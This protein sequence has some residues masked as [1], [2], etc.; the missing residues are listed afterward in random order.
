M[1][2]FIYGTLLYPP[3]FALVSGAP[4]R[5]AAPAFL[6]GFAVET[7]PDGPWPALVKRKGDTARGMV[8]RGLSPGQMRRLDAYERPFGYERAAITLQDEDGDDLEA[9]AWLPSAGQSASGRDWSL[10]AWVR[11]DAAEAMLAAAE[12]DWGAEDFD[13]ADILRQWPM[14]RGR[15]AAQLRASAEE[16]PAQV[17]R[18]PGQGDWNHASRG[19]M[20]GAFFRL[21]TMTMA[22]RRFDGGW[23]RD[24][25]REV[26]VGCDVAL[27]LP[28]DPVRDRVLLVEQFRAGPARRGD[29][30][31]WVLEPVAGIVDA[32]ETPE[33]A[34]LREAR[35]EAGLALAPGDLRPM[36]AAYPSPGNATDHFNAWAALTDLPD[37]F[38]ASGGVAAEGE[39]LRLHV[40]PFTRAME[41]LDSG[42]VT[43]V[44]LV[45]MLLW[46][47]RERP[48]LRRGHG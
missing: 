46:L 32:G 42:E 20:A 15:A 31:P 5:R 1:T 2:L 9:T 16:R 26:F 21:D 12:V 35:E 43:A 19:P 45:A 44:P 14:I 30:N 17:R 18:S 48:D 38:P 40:L 28:Y 13:D 22:H 8:L 41:L 4:L 27:V 47:A 33:A 6:P 25:L 37:G 36:F 24:L 23:N 3:L 11:E 7:S 39:D 34:A 10:S 29:R